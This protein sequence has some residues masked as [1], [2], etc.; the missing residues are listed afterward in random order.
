M[1]YIHSFSVVLF[2]ILSISSCNFQAETKVILGD[3]KPFSTLEENQQ[4]VNDVL[5]YDHASMIKEKNNAIDSK[6]LDGIEYHTEEVGDAVKVEL[7]F[8]GTAIPHTKEIGDYFINFF[9]EKKDEYEEKGKN[10]RD[11]TL[12]ANYFIDLIEAQEYDKIWTLLQP[13]TKEA[14]SQEEFIKNSNYIKGGKKQLQSRLVHSKIR[15]FVGEFYIIN[16][17]YA[18][19][20]HVQVILQPS[21][22]ELFISNY[23]ITPL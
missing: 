13:E 9:Q 1:K 7:R 20:Y 21:G 8:T 22:S 19:K 18:D 17:I 2:F 5:A 4:F 10:I 11:A 14:F 15:Q 12:K 3:L 6:V 23:A 16:Y